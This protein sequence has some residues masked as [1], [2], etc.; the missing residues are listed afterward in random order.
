ME[1]WALLRG[2]SDIIYLSLFFYKHF[3]VGL[4]LYSIG[5]PWTRW[6]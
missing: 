2:A 6:A 4:I 3:R 1:Q 5:V